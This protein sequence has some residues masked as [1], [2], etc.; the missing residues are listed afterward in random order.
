MNGNVDIRMTTLGNDAGPVRA[1]SVNGSVSAYLPEKFD[2]TVKMETVLGQLTNDFG[3]TTKTDSKDLS[4]T[5][6]AG[7]RTIDIGT[8]TGSAALHKLDSQGHG[9]YPAVT[10]RGPATG[11]NCR[12]FHG[13]VRDGFLEIRNPTVTVVRTGEERA[14]LVRRTYTLVLASVLVTI[15]G[16]RSRCRSRA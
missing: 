5:V 13:V 9:G 4:A 8:V 12:V 6:G 11:Y 16:V 15:G 7:G 1:H 2:G 3:G 10:E 14:T